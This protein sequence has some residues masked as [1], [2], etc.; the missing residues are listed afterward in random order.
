M[1][2][3]CIINIKGKKYFNLLNRSSESSSIKIFY[4]IMR[5]FLESTIRRLNCYFGLFYGSKMNR[6]IVLHH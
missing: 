2:I 5:T 6:D 1:R 4:N 3:N